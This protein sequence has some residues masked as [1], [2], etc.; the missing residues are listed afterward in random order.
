MK[1]Y[2][3]SPALDAGLLA[4]AQAVEHYEIS[5]YG[6]LRTWAEE[7]GLCRRGH[8]AAGDPRRREGDR[9]DADRNRRDRSSTRKLRQP[10]PVT[11]RIEILLPVYDNEGIALPTIE[12]AWVREILA[13]AFGGVTFFPPPASR[14]IVEAGRRKSKRDQIVVIAVLVE[15]MDRSWWERFR[16]DLERRFRQ[17]VVV[18]TATTVEVL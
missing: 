18:V 17:K 14:R 13:N 16:G 10:E 1:E 4:A 5:R 9:R 2:K 11:Q 8:A 15:N 12:F 7:L 3:G 6:T